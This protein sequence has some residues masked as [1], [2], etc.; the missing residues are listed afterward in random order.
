[1]DSDTYLTL[2]AIVNFCLI[3]LAIEVFAFATRAN[4]LLLE[5]NSSPAPDCLCPQS[6]EKVEHSPRPWPY[7]CGWP[8]NTFLHCLTDAEMGDSLTS[9]C[10]D[11]NWE[12]PRT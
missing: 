10:T 4:S 7:Q 3:N 1:M 8:T 11:K 5:F 2:A 12:V 9:Q 6:G